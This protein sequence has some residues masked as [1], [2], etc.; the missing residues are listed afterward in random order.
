V[1]EGRGLDGAPYGLC[2]TNVPIGPL[3]PGVSCTLEIS[4]GDSVS[5][6]VATVRYVADRGIGLETKDA[7]PVP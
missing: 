4:R 5:R 3:K 2:V 6:H 7:L 1:F